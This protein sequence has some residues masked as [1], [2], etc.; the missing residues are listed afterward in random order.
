MAF[1]R[2]PSLLL[3]S[4]WF[5]PSISSGAFRAYRLARYL[6]SLGWHPI[7]LSARSP[8][9][10]ARIDVG[11]ARQLGD[12]EVEVYRTFSFPLGQRRGHSRMSPRMQSR[13]G[14]GWVRGKIRR[15]LS[16]LLIPDPYILWLP[17]ALG[18]ALKLLRSRRPDLIYTTGGPWTAHV[19]GLC[20]KRLVRRPWVA[21]FRD[22]WTLA[23]PFHL[24]KPLLIRKF[25][26][27]L[28]QA[29]FRL[30]D[31]VVCVT[32]ETANA[33]LERY[34]HS[35]PQLQHKMFVA[36]NGYDEQM[37]L[38]IKTGVSSVE[39]TN[40]T[41]NVMTFV[42]AGTLT[43]RK[44]EP[45]L[46]GLKTLLERGDIAQS[47]LDVRLYGEYTPEQARLVEELRLGSNVRFMGVVGKEAS[48][49]GMMIADV[50]LYVSEGDISDSF[51]VGAK[52][53]EYLATGKPILG[54][55]DKGPAVRILKDSGLGCLAAVEDERDIARAIQ[56]L[57][58]LWRHD[59]LQR[60]FRANTEYISKFRTSVLV[61]DLAT[62]LSSALSHAGG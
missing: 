16:Y 28:E 27:S 55:V 14:R 5:P 6:P 18:A 52:L 21:E 41:R 26:I 12:T 61:R 3:V 60:A 34:S 13:Y 2:M 56:E 24:R 49:E 19:V 30:A 37:F 43:N 20:L 1:S 54:L 35:V 46:R 42:H 23:W 62:A 51:C 31:A 22:P 8:G 29:V 47:Q 40:R 45:F 33:Y 4:Y 25:E 9:D 11:L 32:E 57:W 7:V 10:S 58:F 59:K 36:S 44:I 17:G 15:L 53:Y 48:I 39:G 50:L 38:G